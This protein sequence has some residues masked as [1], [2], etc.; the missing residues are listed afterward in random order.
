MGGSAA[1]QGDGRIAQVV[2]AGNG[3][4]DPND[5]RFLAVIE[6][7]GAI[8]AVGVGNRRDQG[9]GGQSGIGQG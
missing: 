2:Q 4:G 8:V 6:T 3:P 7:S 5:Q 1:R 9:L